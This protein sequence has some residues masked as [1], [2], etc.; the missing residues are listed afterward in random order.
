LLKAAGLP[1]DTFDPVLTRE[2]AYPDKPDP[3]MVLAACNSWGLPPESCLMVGDTM[4][5]MKCGSKAGCD[6][7]L[8]QP[9]DKAGMKRALEEPESVEKVLSV[10]FV[11][12]S[13]SELEGMVADA[14][15]SS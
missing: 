9:I 3:A 13:L 8:L 2:S 12:S 11:I 1:D 14:L 10:G 6:T 4:D 5:D 7:C 15:E